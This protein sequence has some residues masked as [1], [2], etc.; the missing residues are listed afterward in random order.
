MIYLLED[1]DSIRKLVVYA[2]ESQGFEAEGFG[3]PEPFWRRL[4]QTPCLTPSQRSMRQVFL[5][6][7][8]TAASQTENMC[9]V[10]SSIRKNP[11]KRACR[12]CGIL[13]SLQNDYFSCN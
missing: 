6:H 4:T 5:L 10:H 11:A 1:D 13:R 2:L 12:C 9:S 7:C 3:S 8:L